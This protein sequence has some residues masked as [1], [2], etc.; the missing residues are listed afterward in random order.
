MKVTCNCGSSIVVYDSEKG[1][2]QMNEFLENHKI[3]LELKRCDHY[4]TEPKTPI[5][6]CNL[7]KGH[8]GPHS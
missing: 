5:N 2:E 1:A 7:R 8:V 3:C 4:F 6:R